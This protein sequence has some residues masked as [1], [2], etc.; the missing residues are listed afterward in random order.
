MSPIITIFCSFTRSWAVDVW[1]DNLTHVE[2]DPTRTNLC[3][4]V[5]CDEP[6]ILKKLAEFAKA[7]NYRSFHSRMND[8]WE[9]NEVKLAIRRARIAEVKAQSCDLIAKC[10]G[11]IVIGLEDD[12]VFD[13][14][15][16]FEPLYKLIEQEDGIGFVEGVQMGRWGV[17]MIGA[18]QCDDANDPQRVRTMLPPSK[19]GLQPICAGGFYGY[20]TH[21]DLYLK[22]EYFGSASQPWGPDVNYGLWL[23]R[24]GYSCWINWDLVFGHNDHGTIGYPNKE[25][26]SSQLAQVIYHKDSYGKWQRQDHEIGRYA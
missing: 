11:N 3:V 5:D 19:G 15:P 25:P 10:D 13:S 9:P 23:R 21:K 8:D 2:H 7:R 6:S 17:N 14:L 26:F 22:H 12:T 1:L 4:I 20:A 18:W 24:M 16:S